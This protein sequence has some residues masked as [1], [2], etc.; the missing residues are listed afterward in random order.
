MASVWV[1]CLTRPC[2]TG[3]QN[4]ASGCSVWGQAS[5]WRSDSAAPVNLPLLLRVPV[6]VPAACACCC[7]CLLLPV[8]VP[9]PVALQSLA[10]FPDKISDSNLK[11]VNALKGVGKGTME[12]VSC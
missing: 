8:R 11:A 12:R 4:L 10:T 7:L 9:V 3:F 1:M 6:P 2:L 5:A